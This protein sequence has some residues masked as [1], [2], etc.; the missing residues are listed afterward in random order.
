MPY[1]GYII[2]PFL[3]FIVSKLLASTL[4]I[5]LLIAPSANATPP[6]KKE[7]CLTVSKMAQNV[8][9]LRQIG[10]P[11]SRPLE[12]SQKFAADGTDS[13]THTS[14][15]MDGIIIDAYSQPLRYSEQMQLSS[16]TEFA[17]KYYLICMQD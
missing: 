15:L 9:G 16:I 5:C 8:M 14:E 10:S 17:T 2:Y 6:I 13:G 3:G 4:I 12:I 11:I 1:S 7:V